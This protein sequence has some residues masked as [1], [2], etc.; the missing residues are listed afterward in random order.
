MSRHTLASRLA[1]GLGLTL[2]G[3]AACTDQVP[4]TSAAPAERPAAL[5]ARAPQE[6]PPRS[7]FVD[8]VAG[9]DA[10]PGTQ[11]APYRTLSRALGL[12]TGS[13]TIVLAAGTYSAATNG[14]RYG[15][16]TRFA[17]VPAGLVIRGPTVAAGGV[18]NAVLVGAPGEIGLTFEGNAR[19]SGV[20]LSG[21][22][23]GV[24]ASRGALAMSDVAITQDRGAAG[25]QLSGSAY[26]TVVNGVFTPTSAAIV[27]ADQSQLTLQGGRVGAAPNCGQTGVGVRLTGKAKA[28]VVDALFQDVPGSALTVDDS[29]AAVLQ[30]TTVSRSAPAGCGP[31]TASLKVALAGRLELRGSTVRLQN[32]PNGGW[33]IGVMASGGDGVHL[34]LDSTSFTGFRTTTP[35]AGTA[36]DFRGNGT[37]V[38]RGGGTDATGLMADNG[39][40]VIAAVP[41]AQVLIDGM[42]FRGN[43]VAIAGCNLKLR[44]SELRQNVV[45]VL[46]DE[47]CVA[48]LGTPIWPGGNA[49]ASWQTG[50]TVVGALEGLSRAA[51]IYAVGNAW[52]PNVQG[53]DASGAELARTVTGASADA[54]GLNF[55]LRSSQSVLHL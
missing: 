10:G 54:R 2:A 15:T 5:V 42:R 36:V 7:R 19:V 24:R 8:P 16:A 34:E 11:A 3:L 17:L 22:D 41:A 28:I 32:T 30:H 47:N 1:L 13:D 51:E 43:D 27:A 45:G 29:A 31:I 26:V 20:A 44:H 40:A 18:P 39:R 9:D 46:V 37:L 14:E 6:Q 23:V 50:V 21:F 48:D 4:P 52:F 25:L 35:R 49:F 12:A 53:A 55:F 38:M 33:P